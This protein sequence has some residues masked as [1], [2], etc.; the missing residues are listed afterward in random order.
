[1]GGGTR[2]KSIKSGKSGIIAIDQHYDQL[3]ID[4]EVEHLR[5]STEFKRLVE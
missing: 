1:M 2:G 5:Y 3:N 4:N